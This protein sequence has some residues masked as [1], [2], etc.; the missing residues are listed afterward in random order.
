[1]GGL[2]CGLLLCGQDKPPAMCSVSGVVVDSITGQPLGKAQVRMQRA[3]R[4]RNDAGTVTN[5]DGKFSM[6]GLVSGEYRLYAQRN[7]YQ[8]MHLGARRADSIGTI[9]SLAEGQD[10]TGLKVALQPYA[11]IAGTVRDSDGEPMVGTSVQAFHWAFMGNKRRLLQEGYVR[12]DDLG[13][14]RL[15]DLRPGK[16]LLRADPRIS[17]D[18]D[19][20]TA[21]GRKR[22]EYDIA[23]YYPGAADWSSAMPWKWSPGGESAES[24]SP[25]GVADCSG[26]WA[27]SRL[28][29]ACR[30]RPSGCSSMRS[31]R[32]RYSPTPSKIPESVPAA[33]SSS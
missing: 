22:P 25:Y 5:A 28:G 30:V 33:S 2:F 26:S 21:G 29:K 15:A 31:R 17:T 7:G 19:D 6:S 13:Q 8:P 11:V 32:K 20:R 3:P 12:T 24:I 14:F 18:V 27:G 1:M 16:Y 23:T 10:A 9:L 4:D